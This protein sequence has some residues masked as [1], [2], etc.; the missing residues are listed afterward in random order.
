MGSNH[1]CLTNFGCISSMIEYD[2]CSGNIQLQVISSH[3]WF[4]CIRVGQVTFEEE[5]NER[6]TKRLK[7]ATKGFTFPQSL[8]RKSTRI[9]GGSCSKASFASVAV[10]VCVVVH[11][12]HHQQQ[13]HDSISIAKMILPSW[14]VSSVLDFFSH[15]SFVPPFLR[16]K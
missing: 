5:L 4:S 12:R 8:L 14:T 1:Y 7:G 11:H 6:Q 3:A 2:H 10:L 9:P 15:S 13:H 16:E